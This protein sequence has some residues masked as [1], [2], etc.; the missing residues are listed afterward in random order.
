[1]L[2]TTLLILCYHKF[3]YYAIILEAK[4]AEVFMFQHI[5]YYPVCIGYLL[6]FFINILNS[7]N[8][9]TKKVDK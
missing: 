4:I 7:I 9:I 3:I 2:E 1:M 5:L 6:K 8:K